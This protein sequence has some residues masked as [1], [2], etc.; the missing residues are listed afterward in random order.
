MRNNIFVT[1]IPE[2]MKSTNIKIPIS[3]N[4][5][6]VKELAVKDSYVTQTIGNNYV[7]VFEEIFTV[8]FKLV[9]NNLINY[10]LYLQAHTGKNEF[11]IDK[12]FK[13]QFASFCGKKD[14]PKTTFYRLRVELIKFNYIVEGENK[15]FFIN[16]AMSFTGTKTERIE[17]TKNY[18]YVK[19]KKIEK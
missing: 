15:L 12:Q 19:N 11:V 1:T 3:K 13:K 9:N 10:I 6:Y 5:V 7:Q 14:I 18:Y 16:P 4:K 2:I 17:A 8:F